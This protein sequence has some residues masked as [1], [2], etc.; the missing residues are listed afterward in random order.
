MIARLR[1][2]SAIGRERQWRGRFGSVDPIRGM[3]IASY[4]V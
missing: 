1:K 4:D 2:S 3:G